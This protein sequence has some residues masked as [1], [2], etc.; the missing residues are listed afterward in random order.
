M[1]L[2]ALFGAVV[3]ALTALADANTITPPYSARVSDDHVLV[4]SG[5]GKQFYA[6][7][8][9]HRGDTVTV[10]RQEDDGWCAI[11]PP[12]GSHCWVVSTYVEPTEWAD[13]GEIK[14]DNVLAY[15]GSNLDDQR[16]AVQVRMEKGER[17]RLLGVKRWVD[18][19]SGKSSTWYRIEPPA[20]EFRWVSGRHLSPIHVEPLISR[21]EPEPSGTALANS[22]SATPPADKPRSTIRT[23]PIPRPSLTDTIRKLTDAP[24]IDAA[25]TD[26]PR[27]QELA[28]E[29]SARPRGWMPRPEGVS[30]G[31]TN[32][33]YVSQSAHQSATNITP[34]VFVANTDSQPIRVASATVETSSTP[35]SQPIASDSQIADLD[36]ALSRMVAR[37]PDLW[38]LQPLKQ[39]AQ[40]LFNTASTPLQRGEAKLLLDKIEQF[41]NLQL[42]R[43]QMPSSLPGSTGGISLAPASMNTPVSN[44]TAA[45]E[46]ALLGAEIGDDNFEG[47]GVLQQVVQRYKNSVQAQNTPAYAL[48]DD[49]GNFVAFVSPSPGLNLRRYLKAEVGIRGRRADLAGYDPV[50]DT[51][52]P[53]PHLVADRVVVIERKRW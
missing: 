4:R 3:C 31:G 36:L 28:A 50:T 22:T 2:I 19:N 45:A 40:Q 11:R 20:G 9:V 24:N 52:A 8:K 15:I 10:F 23:Y 32:E 26:R 12:S 39:R 38:Q 13:V 29:N 46:P 53:R 16:S 5:P 48:T 34:A 17:V 27:P 35:S 21:N 14:V 25:T 33:R 49:H 7:G 44:T 47:V 42:K 18:P 30:R 1:R 43:Q 37:S 41:I 6:T 51:V